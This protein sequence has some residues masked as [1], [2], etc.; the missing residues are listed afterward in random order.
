MNENLLDYLKSLEEN[1]A[2]TMDNEQLTSRETAFTSYVLSQ[3]AT[4]KEVSKPAKSSE[5][6]THPT[7]HNDNMRGFDPA[8]EDDTHDNGMSRYMENYDEEGWD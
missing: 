7:H 5:P 2:I 1:T 4:K 8:S 6:N 3:I